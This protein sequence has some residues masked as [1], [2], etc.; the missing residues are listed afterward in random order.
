M[1]KGNGT[2]LQ[3]ITKA[4]IRYFDSAEIENAKSWILQDQTVETEFAL[5]VAK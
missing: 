1:G 2:F 4:K 5:K 3:T